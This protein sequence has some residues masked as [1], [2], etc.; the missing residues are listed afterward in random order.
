[1]RINMRK[2][3]I[4]AIIGLLPLFCAGGP[5][6]GL[7]AAGEENPLLLRT[8]T[9]HTG[10]VL[11]VTYSPDGKK[12]ASGS[13]D[14]TVR[15]WDVGRGECERTLTGH[16]SY[17]NSVTYSPDGK[18]LASGS[19]DGTVRIWDVGRGECE[20]TL[21]GHTGYV[22]SVTYSPDG[23]KL[24]SGSK[25]GTVRIWMTPMEQE[26]IAAEKAAEKAAEAA[27]AAKAAEEERIVKAA[28][29][30][31]ADAAKKAEKYEAHMSEGN[32]L[33]SSSKPSEIMKAVR[34]YQEALKYGDTPEA[35]AKLTQA[36]QK[37][38][39]SVER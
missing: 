15:I 39:R 18:K 5:A 14:G 36:Q 37:Y 13:A 8:L 35:R 30:A 7:K 34:E 31:A 9:G 38:E 24:A 2:K 22:L 19:Y 25:D 17:V 23:K 16:T 4:A 3:I 32:R 1:M 11:S 6:D 26:R 29:A 12:L 20:R 27:R 28:A 33:L 10:G 21:T